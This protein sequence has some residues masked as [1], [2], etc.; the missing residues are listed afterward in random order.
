MPSDRILTQSEKEREA[1]RTV[2]LDRRRQWHLAYGGDCPEAVKGK[3]ANQTGCPNPSH[4]TGP[5]RRKA[6]HDL[7]SDTPAPSP[8]PETPAD[9][10]DQD[11]SAE[12]GII[13]ETDPVTVDG[14]D[15][16]ALMAAA[17]A[18]IAARSKGAVDADQVRGIVQTATA[19]LLARVEAIEKRA[20]LPV[21]IKVGDAPV[22]DVGLAHEKFPELV[23]RA[24]A[25]MADGFAP[26]IMLIGPAGSGKTTAAKQLAKALGVPYFF[27]GAI[28]SE[29]KLTGFVDA[30]GRMVSTAFRA[31]YPIPSVYLFDE[32]DVSLPSA[33]LA[34]NAALGNGH[35]DFPG[36]DAPIARHPDCVIM[37]GANTNGLGGTA[38]FNGRFKMD[39]AFRD[40]FSFMD[41]PVD[42]T[43]ERA[44]AGNDKW[45][46]YVQRLR[47]KVKGLGIKVQISPRASIRGAAL[48]A[49]GLTWSQ[50]VDSE[51]KNRMSAE[52]FR[53][54]SK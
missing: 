38:E 19:A 50:V 24:K 46:S 41:W 7:C 5:I 3:C 37:A 18:A 26:N 30:N 31:A 29:Y 54:V 34:F 28:D 35:A 11:E 1:L 52:D 45:T 51:I 22:I 32:V 43:L 25:R 48:L 42:E 53:T 44:C 17:V 8:D 23:Q 27:N 36:A 13:E 2:D 15:P 14:N 21:H 10:V 40:R 16:A 39:E 47:A 49:A 9:A 4:W 12:H 6:F 33:C 20:A